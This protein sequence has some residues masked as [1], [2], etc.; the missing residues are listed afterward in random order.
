MLKFLGWHRASIRSRNSLARETSGRS[1]LDRLDVIT[2]PKDE[3]NAIGPLL[4]PTRQIFR[5]KT[6]TKLLSEPYR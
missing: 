3:A 6:I 2:T 4:S 5:Y 1:T